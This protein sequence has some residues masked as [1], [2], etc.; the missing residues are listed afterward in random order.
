MPNCWDNNPNPG[1]AFH[2]L[3]VLPT[4]A[5]D[6]VRPYQVPGTV[7]IIP[8]TAVAQAQ[9]NGMYHAVYW[10]FDVS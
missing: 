3:I 7:A 4:V 1:S 8:D 5:P 10:L 6:L 2:E 9:S